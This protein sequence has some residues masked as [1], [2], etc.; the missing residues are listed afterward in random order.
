MNIGEF[1]IRKKTVTL[2]LTLAL[3]IGGIYAYYGLGRLEDPEFTIKDA[4]VI[5]QYPG[6]TAREVEEEVTDKLETAIQQLGQLKRVRSKS[7]YGLSFIYVTIKDQYTSKDLPQVWDELRR[8]VN[9]VQSSLPPGAG[10]SIVNDDYGDVFGVFYAVTGDGYT[11]AEIKDYVD[12]LRRELLLVKDVAKVSLIGVQTEAVYVEMSRAKLAALGLNPQVIYQTLQQQN[13]VTTTGQTEVGTEYIRIDPTGAL[14]SIDEIENLLI[15]GGGSSGSTIYLKDVASVSRDYV[16]PPSTMVRFDGQLAIGLGISTV[17]GGNVVEMGRAVKKR[18]KEL[19][20][21]APLGME[22]GVIAL[23]SDTVEKSI[24]NFITNLIEAVAIVIG[25]LLVFMGLRSGL[26]IGF[27]LLLTI[28]ATFMVMKFFRIDL[29]SVSLGALIIALGMLVD[30]AIVVAEGTLVKIETGVDRIKAA[31]STVASTLMPLLGA[32]VVGILAFAAIGLSPDS[33]GEYCRSLFEVVGISLF[34]SWILAVTVVPVLCVMFMKPKAGQE[35]PYGGGFYQGYKKLLRFALKRRI[36]AIVLLA[37]LLVMA[38][39]GFNFV[40]KA[41]FP[42]NDRPQFTIDLW[43]PEGTYIKDTSQRLARIESYLA[44]QENVDSWAAFVGAGALRFILTYSPESNNS[45]YGQILVSIKDHKTM[46]ETMEAC[47]A[48]IDDHF[49]DS[50]GMVKLFS[51]GSAGTFKIEAR[52]RGP[53][54]QVLRGL[55][56]QAEEIMQDNRRAEFVNTDWRQKV[57]V[58]RPI[59]S[60]SRSRQIGIT[61]PD[62]TNA[63]EWAFNGLTIGLYREDNKLLPIITRP[64]EQERK[65][66]DYVNDIQVWSPVTQSMLNLNQIVSDYQ[67]VFQDSIIWRRNRLPTITVM[68]DPVDGNANALLASLR[69]DVEAIELPVGYTLEWGGEYESSQDANNGLMKLLPVSFIMM[70]LVIIMLFNA[71]RQPLIIIL[72]L[73]LAIIGVTVGLLVMKQPFSF[74]AML[75]FLSLVGMLI[76]NAIVLLDQIDIEIR[77][78]KQPY[79]AILDSCVSRFRPVLMAA[80]TTILGMFPLLFDSLFAPMAVTIMFGLLF[81]TILTLLV[82]PILYMLFFRIK[83]PSSARS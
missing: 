59:V 45:A 19:E 42:P 73:P 68:S 57:K 35:D 6:A 66:I 55:A 34:L 46:A 79:A 54:H 28:L 39:S 41:F 4:V 9:D 29:Q 51:R 33:T 52:F 25:L 80:L 44:E 40:D 71:L 21:E 30:N 77:E 7:S 26:L 62:I 60:E 1:C 16:D 49:P 13:L 38:V 27:T 53:D 75:G 63:I 64:P 65:N 56:R 78:G 20:A 69:P 24:N 15:S 70:A 31:S 74:M 76:K 5:T 48:F 22:T 18:M 83:E 3:F 17:S 43:A 23:Q 32:T 50:L 81:A 82:V 10:P 12:M 36:P 67:T 11:Y 61:R 72:C 14:D 47:Q 8:K 58:L 2:V 37:V